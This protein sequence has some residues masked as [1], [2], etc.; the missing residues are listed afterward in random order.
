[1]AMTKVNGNRALHQ[2]CKIVVHNFLELLRPN[3]NLTCRSK[4]ILRQRCG[5]RRRTMG[6]EV[7]EWR[8]R[9]KADT[10]LSWQYLSQQSSFTTDAGCTSTL[11]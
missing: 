8:G 7:E 9:Q 5:R 4:A 11:C 2:V 10:A 1:M 3:R 6:E